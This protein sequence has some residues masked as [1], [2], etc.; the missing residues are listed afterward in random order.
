MKQ[1]ESTASPKVV[2]TIPEFCSTHGDISRQFLHKLIKDGKGPRLMK[3]GRRTL[4]TA[5]AAADW[6]KQMEN[7]SNP[8]WLDSPS[9]VS[10]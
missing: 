8:S 2:F 5:E 7:E 1:V 3:V 4:I 6:R 9:I 10:L